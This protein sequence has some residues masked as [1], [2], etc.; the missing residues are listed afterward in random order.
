MK[1]FLDFIRD[2]NPM[3]GFELLASK[4]VWAR[5][6]L[7][8]MQRCPPE[9]LIFLGI[10]NFPHGQFDHVHIFSGSLAVAVHLLVMPF[11]S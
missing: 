8:S 11:T 1:S 6:W 7:A 2:R 4:G 5:Q 9:L 3:P 10:G